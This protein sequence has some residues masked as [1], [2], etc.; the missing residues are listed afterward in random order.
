MSRKADLGRAREAR[1]R[2]GSHLDEIESRFMP[3]HVARIAR[4]WAGH[5]AR[6]HP[7]AWTLGATAVGATVLGLIGWAIFSRDD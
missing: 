5:S 4:A 3:Q 7:V 2:L 6:K 1:N